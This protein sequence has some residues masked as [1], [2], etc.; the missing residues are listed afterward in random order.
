ML[1]LHS[2]QAFRSDPVGTKTPRPAC[3]RLTVL[4]GLQIFVAMAAAM[5]RGEVLVVSVRLRRLWAVQ[6][7]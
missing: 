3:D 2:T 7:S 1:E 4:R 6:V 5:I